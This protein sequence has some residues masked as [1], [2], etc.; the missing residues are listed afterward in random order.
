M[1]SEA[2]RTYLQGRGYTPAMLAAEPLSGTD[3]RITIECRSM[4]G[5]LIGHQTLEEYL[6][7]DEDKRY[8]WHQANGAGH[9]PPMYGTQEDH[10]TLFKTGRCVLT[11]GFFDRTAMKAMFP[12]L[13]VYA[14]LSKGLAFPMRRMLARY[15][16]HVILAFD[17]D[18]P[19]RSATEKATKVLGAEPHMTVTTLEY[20]AKDPSKLLKDKG[21]D[22][23]KRIIEPQMELF[24]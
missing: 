21:L 10:T 12:E 4:S 2:S 3:D 14:R 9:L 19:G 8:R 17:M 22:G 16:H 23:A 7:P 24:L 1:I 5:A 18:P 11:E 15:G 13:A 20:P 6:G